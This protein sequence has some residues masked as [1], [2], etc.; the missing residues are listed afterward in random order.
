MQV[1]RYGYV[2]TQPDKSSSSNKRVLPVFS[3]GCQ[4]CSISLSTSGSA[5]FHEVAA[6]HLWGPD[7]LLTRRMVS[8]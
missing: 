7:V 5:A 8:V 1:R 6:A 3:F 4:S 2:Q